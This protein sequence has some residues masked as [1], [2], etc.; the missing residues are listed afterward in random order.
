M[1]EK[2]KRI[3]DK[4]AIEEAR[5][6]YCEYC[7][8]NWNLQVHHVK[9]KGSGGGDVPENLITLCAKCHTKAHNG[10]ISK[11][12]L[13]AR[14]RPRKTLEERLTRL[15]ELKEA[16]RATS[17]SFGDEAA[18]TVDEYGRG[19]IKRIANDA[20]CSA[21]WVRQV[22]KIARAFPKELRYPDVDWSIYRE[23]YYAAGR[24]KKPIQEVFKHVLDNDLHCADI[25]KLGASKNKKAKLKVTCSKC[26]LEQSYRHPDG[27]MAGTRIY[28]PVCAEDGQ[29]HLVGVLEVD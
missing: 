21:E 7:V 19:A 23:T 14:K 18:E 8:S 17:W 29:K 11:E 9:S 28:C 27:G 13:R 6:D 5:K 1:L 15:A 24:E 4:K 2:P 22:I 3:E 12:E 26:G 25:K 20:H 10:E 16:G